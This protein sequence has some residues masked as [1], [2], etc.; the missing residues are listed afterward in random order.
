MLPIVKTL[1]FNR[2][3]SSSFEALIDEYHLLD[4]ESKGFLVLDEFVKKVRYFLT[5]SRY[6]KN[7]DGCLAILTCNNSFTIQE[8]AS[9][10]IPKRNG[11]YCSISKNRVIVYFPTCRDGEIEVALNHTFNVPKETLFKKIQAYY[12]G[13]DILDYI[14]KIELNK[15]HALDTQDEKAIVKML[16]LSFN[17][18]EAMKNLK[19]FDEMAKGQEAITPTPCDLDLLLGEHDAV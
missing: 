6:L 5:T 18:N 12:K 3:I 17:K 13:Q 11:D 4:R 1:K 15:V 9:Q 2:T 14:N 7:N 8:C 16:Q 19:S 10:F